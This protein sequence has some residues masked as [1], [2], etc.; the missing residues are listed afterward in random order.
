M[1]TYPRDDRPA[2]EVL[3]SATDLTASYARC[4][5][6]R[7]PVEQLKPG[8]ILSETDL[9]F[10][11]EVN[12]RLLLVTDKIIN[13]ICRFGPS[14]SYIV[15]LCDPKLVALKLYASRNALIMA[16]KKGIFPGVVF[17]EESCG[18]NAISLARELGK[19]VAIRAEQHYFALFKNWWCIAGPLRSGK[20]KIIGYLDIS[21]PAEKA[22]GLTAELLKALLVAIEKE[23]LL[24]D[25][26]SIAGQ[27]K[28]LSTLPPEMEK[29]LSTREKEIIKLLFLRL[30]SREIAAVLHI[31]VS[32][33]NSHR[34]NIYEKLGVKGLS[35]LLAKYD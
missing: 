13:A 14:D 30:S 5:K 18:T 33:V 16:E 23:I 17:T 15:I 9:D 2:T 28:H 10:R 7:L 3:C 31:S 27:Q 4:R 29:E 20:M 19:I 25:I 11:L 1:I 32:T 21:M 26:E 12:N 22:F 8:I 6:V 34:R 35:G 24:L